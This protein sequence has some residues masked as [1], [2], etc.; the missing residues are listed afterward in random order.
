MAVTYWLVMPAAGRGK[1]LGADRPKQYLN[2]LDRSMIEWSLDVFLQDAACRGGVVAVAPEDPDW[3]QVRSRLARQVIEAPG[4]AQRSD[5]VRQALETL[6]TSGAADEDWVLVH[7]AARPC[8]THGEVQALLQAVAAG[9]DGGLLALP[10]ADTLKRTE[11][12]HAVPCAQ[13]TVPREALWRALTPQMFRL[14]PLLM[15]LRACASAQRVPTDEAQAME[16]QGLRPRLVTGESTNLKV[17]TLADLA[18]AES[19]LHRRRVSR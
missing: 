5:S 6:R 7:D 1:R 2:L 10:L 18:L 14:G 4:G 11:A 12:A 17:T 16:W 9:A 3:P 15:A 8:V 13:E 19:I